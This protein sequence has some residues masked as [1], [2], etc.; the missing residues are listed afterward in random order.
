M[1]SYLKGVLTSR[2]FDI[3]GP[4]TNKCDKKPLGD[5]LLHVIVFL[6]TEF[7]I[8]QQKNILYE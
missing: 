6:L 8:L 5:I 7:M 3:P 1:Q 2:L 4:K